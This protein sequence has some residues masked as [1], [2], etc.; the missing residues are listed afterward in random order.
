MTQQRQ[1]KCVL[2]VEDDEDIAEM[3]LFSLEGMGFQVEAAG[4]GVEAIEKL[5]AREFD[6]VVSDLKMPRMDGFGLAKHIRESFEK[7]P[8]LLV[9]GFAE[10]DVREKALTLGVSSV[11]EKP[12][13]FEMLESEMQKTWSHCLQ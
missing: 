1:L 2:L 11:M 13:D 7:L 12:T 6:M 3:M 4:D 8:M 5:S 10:G 9:T